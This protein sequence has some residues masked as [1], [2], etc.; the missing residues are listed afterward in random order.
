[1]MSTVSSIWKVEAD[2]IKMP[3]HGKVFKLDTLPVNIAA[4]KPVN[5]SS[6]FLGDGASVTDGDCA[7]YWQSESSGPQWAYVDLG[8]NQL[9]GRVNLIWA[10]SFAPLF[11]LQLSSDLNTWWIAYESDDPHAGGTTSIDLSSNARYIRALGY[12]RS[13][14]FGLYEMQV[15]S[16]NAS[17]P[18]YCVVEGNLASGRPMYEQDGTPSRLG[19]LAND[20]NYA[21]AWF[22]NNEFPP[23]LYVDLGSVQPLGKAKIY[24]G[25][26]SSAFEIQV[27]NDT[28]AWAMV[29]DDEGTPYGVNVAT[30]SVSAQYVK[31]FGTQYDFDVAEFELY[32]S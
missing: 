4:G 6:S 10:T 8:S 15:F 2:L 16:Q 26:Y 17:V 23:T 27:S 14:P 11:Q 28:K 19:Y 5:V 22:T 18:N 31:V 9:I 32:S 30:L 24:W 29:Y 21:T 20:G 1:M 12:M 13:G 7:T 3:S 25:T